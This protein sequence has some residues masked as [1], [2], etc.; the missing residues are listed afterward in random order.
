MVKNIELCGYLT[1]TPVQAYTIPA[2]ITGNDVIGIAQ[3]GWLPSFFYLF[4]Y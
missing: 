4:L 2:V 1:P 3:T